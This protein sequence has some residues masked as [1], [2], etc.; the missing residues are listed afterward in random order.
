MEYIYKTGWG[1]ANRQNIDKSFFD[2]I[3]N[4]MQRTTLFKNKQLFFQYA[5]LLYIGGK[6]RIEPFLMPVTITKI[7]EN[8]ISYYEM[9]SALAKHFDGSAVK[10]TECGKIFK[11]KKEWKAHKKDEKHVHYSHYGERKY[12]ET[13][14]ITDNVYE[15]ALMQ[16]LLRGRQIMT[17]DFTPLL[18]PRFQGADPDKLL[19]MEYQSSLFSGITKKFN[20]FRLSITDGKRVVEDSN[21]VPHMLRHMR[22]YDLK[23]IHGYGTDFLQ[24]YFGWDREAMVEYY[25]D[26]KSMLGKEAMLE[27]IKRH[28]VIE[29]LVAMQ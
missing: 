22:A 3:N 25:L 7:E 12:I 17:I 20:I 15:R 24:K 2:M 6:R 19:G 18:P 1:F 23:I 5:I 4:A 11:V 16:Y 9:K 21:I 13:Y 28:K 29:P 10:C 8:K 14:I 26:I 27:E